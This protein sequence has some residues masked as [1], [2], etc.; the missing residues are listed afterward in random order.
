MGINEALPSKWEC[1]NDELVKRDSVSS[2]ELGKSLAVTTPV[3]GVV[4]KNRTDNNFGTRS[5]PTLTSYPS[6]VIIQAQNN[7]EWDSRSMMQ[8]IQ[9]YIQNPRLRT[10]GKNQELNF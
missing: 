2:D 5:P 8:V 4:P 10:N 1:V 9:I 7:S 3:T 6:T